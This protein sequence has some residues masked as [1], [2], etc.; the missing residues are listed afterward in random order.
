MLAAQCQANQSTA[1]YNWSMI[2]DAYAKNIAIRP[3]R[4][5]DY[6]RL[7]TLIAASARAL[8]HDDYTDQEIEAAIAHVFGVDSELVADGSYFVVERE[9]EC[10]ACGGW[11][12]RRTLFGGDQCAGRE[13][14]FL[15][16]RTEA[17]KLRAFFVHPDHARQGIGTAL[18]LH[19]ESEAKS[20]SFTEMEMMA[21][22]PGV[23]LYRRF[24]YEGHEIVICDT[25]AG[26]IRFVPMRKSLS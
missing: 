19:C 15:D 13:S 14:G 1:R 16:P 25:A 12:R 26:P 8:S 24:G 6:G 9:G 20:H 5:E 17:A 22:L 18:L 21:T 2:N 10:V 23:K 4:N 3:A 11:S 7:Q